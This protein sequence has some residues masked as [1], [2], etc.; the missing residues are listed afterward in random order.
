MGRP[1]LRFD[2]TPF[3]RRF[4]AL[5]DGLERALELEHMRQTQALLDNR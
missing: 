2:V 3:A 4:S 5:S 1:L